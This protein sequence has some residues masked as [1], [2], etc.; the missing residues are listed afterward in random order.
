MM[1]NNVINIVDGTVLWYLGGGVKLYKY[2]GDLVGRKQVINVV[3]DVGE[4]RKKEY[5]VEYKKRELTEE[6][7]QKRIKLFKDYD[8]YIK[9]LDNVIPCFYLNGYEGDEI[10]CNLLYVYKNELRNF[11]ECRIIIHTNDWDLFQFLYLRNVS[12]Y[13]VN[14]NVLVNAKNIK[15]ILG[16]Y[17]E[18]VILEKVFVGDKYDNIKG[19]VTK[20]EFVKMLNDESYFIDV[21]S[22]D[23]NLKKVLKNIYLIFLG[24]ENS[25]V[26]YLSLKLKNWKFNSER[27]RKMAGVNFNFFRKLLCVDEIDERIFYNL[28]KGSSPLIK[29]K[30]DT[31]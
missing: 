15:K 11:D 25:L 3:F 13:L 24:I 6:E 31:K 8:Y 27:F 7:K 4:S 20:E 21:L 9:V 2:I 22:I 30:G 10:I 23:D 5:Y 17:W 18:E 14:R 12:V 16:K 26:D 1:R 19:I 29:P 28:Y